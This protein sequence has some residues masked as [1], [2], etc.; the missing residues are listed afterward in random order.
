MI[1]CTSFQSLISMP[2]FSIEKVIHTNM[3]GLYF[4]PVGQDREH[5]ML[6]VARP[7]EQEIT[8]YIVENKIDTLYLNY[9]KGWSGKDL[10]FLT[11]LKHLKEF[12]IISHEVINI[13]GLHILTE[14]EYLSLAVGNAKTK[15]DF[16]AFN[17]LKNCYFEWLKGSDSI[18]GCSSLEN[19]SLYGY[20]GKSFAEISKLKHLKRLSIT[21]NR[22]IRELSG[23]AKLIKLESLRLRGMTKLESTEELSR[24]ESLKTLWI[25]TCKKIQNIDFIAELT[26]LTEVRLINLGK[27]TSLEPLLQCRELE[28][29]DFTDSTTITDGDLSILKRIPNL[30]KIYFI[31]RRHYSN[32][33]EDFQ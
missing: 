29:L 19:L 16:S 13:E 5:K 7:W 8:D 28:Y 33:Q 4:A 9:V 21:H 2:D 3:D 24:L 31:N 18:F 20:N 17:K 11:D 23:V 22:T 26:K 30:K 27:I 25:S 6:V 12:K 10:D 15:L 1:S 14:L 32:K